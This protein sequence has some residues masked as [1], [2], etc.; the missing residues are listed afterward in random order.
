MTEKR[1]IESISVVL[2]KD[3]PEEVTIDKGIY[4]LSGFAEIRVERENPAVVEIKDMGAE[5]PGKKFSRL[6]KEAGIKSK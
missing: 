4:D 1:K 3:I 5:S 2:K 6:L